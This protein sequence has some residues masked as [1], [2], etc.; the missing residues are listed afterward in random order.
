LSQRVIVAFRTRGRGKKRKVYP[1]TARVGSKPKKRIP[2]GY[3]WPRFTKEVWGWYKDENGQWKPIYGR[4]GGRRYYVTKAGQTA[5]DL[6]PVKFEQRG[7]LA[8]R[9]RNKNG[10]IL[11]LYAGR[12]NLSKNVYM[13]HAGRLIL[14]DSDA[15]ALRIAH[16]RLGDR[17][18]HEEYAMDNIAFIRNV[19]PKLDLDDLTLVDFDPFGS[20]A[21]VAK[22][23][24]SVYK[25]RK[26]LYVAFTDGSSQHNRFIQNEE[27]RRWLRQ[28]YGVNRIPSATREG[29]IDTLDRFMQLQGKKHGFTVE[30]ISVGH[31]DANTVY[32]GYLLR[33][34]RGR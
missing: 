19:L 10:T 14:V 28:T 34:K 23:F 27:G 24:F 17:V 21:K 22:E 12:G 18:E 32:V 25:V 15:K 1:I 8:A 3:S 13:H 16:R 26:P 4:S 31:G 5:P 29:V 7:R 6:H 33:P 11:E 2:A 30:R 20:P 9:I